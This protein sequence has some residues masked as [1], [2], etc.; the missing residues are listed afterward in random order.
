MGATPANRYWLSLLLAV[1]AAGLLVRLFIIQ[2]DCGHGS[3][4]RSRSANDHLGRLLS[5]LTLTPYG[6]W[7]QGH[8]AHHASTG[9][10]DRRGRGDVETWT[11]EEYWAASSLKRV[12]YR[13]Y[14][15]PLV[16]VGFGAPINFIILQRLP[17]HDNKDSRRSILG[18]N[19]ALVVT[20][21]I[22]C[23]S[24]GAVHVLKIYLPVIIIAAWVGNWLFYVQHQFHA[25]DWE[26]DHDW[27]FHA[28]S[29]NGSSHFKL[30]PIL[31]WFSGNI[32][33]HHVHHLCSRVPNYHLQACVDAAP[34]LIPIVNVVTLRESLGCW[35]LALW[36]ERRR[37]LVSFRDALP[38][39]SQ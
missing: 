25:A 3:F 8:A 23:F 34:E 29:L 28:A 17:S 2:H 6:S 24:F 16:M 5:V 10:L 19:L 38:E 14:R 9:N 21:G 15:N 13:L 32:G 27:N 26:R 12:L 18:L 30:P 39:V 7:A 22:A 36:D 4:F 20:F 11:V 33:I 1:P 35:R 31:G 37:S